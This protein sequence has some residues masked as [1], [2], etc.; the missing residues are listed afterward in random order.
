[1]IISEKSGEEGTEN[2]NDIVDGVNG[3]VGIDD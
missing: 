2:D 1:V 3:Q